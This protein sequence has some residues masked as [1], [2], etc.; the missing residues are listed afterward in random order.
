MISEVDDVN[1]VFDNG[2]INGRL[3]PSDLVH[4]DYV[5]GNINYLYTRYDYC[6][7]YIIL[8]DKKYSLCKNNNML[9]EY[10]KTV[11]KIDF[12]GKE[13]LLKSEDNIQ[14]IINELVEKYNMPQEL[15]ANVEEYLFNIKAYTR[16][17]FFEAIED[18]SDL[19]ERFKTFYKSYIK[20]LGLSNFEELM[21]SKDN[22]VAKMFKEDVIDSFFH[23]G[24]TIDLCNTYARVVYFFKEADLLDNKEKLKLQKEIRRCS[25]ESPIIYAN[26]LLSLV[27]YSCGFVKEINNHEGKNIQIFEYHNLEGVD[28]LDSLIKI[29]NSLLPSIKKNCSSSEKRTKIENKISEYQLRLNKKETRKVRLEEKMGK[30]DERNPQKD[31]L[32][33]KYTEELNKLNKEISEIES[34]ISRMQLRK[35]EYV[36]EYVDYNEFFRHLRNS[37]A[38]ANY[39]IDYIKALDKKQFNQIKYTF[40]DF[41]DDNPNI[42]EF[43]LEI[44]AR[45]LLKLVESLEKRVIKQTEIENT[46]EYYLGNNNTDEELKIKRPNNE[47]FENNVN[48]EILYEVLMGSKSNLINLLKDTEEKGID[49]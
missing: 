17:N 28:W 8:G 14:D 4:F 31:K 21:T 5:L 26:I 34:N 35:N 36:S 1:V 46:D 40:E 27:N 25:N 49:D 41:S 18:K 48:E 33:I 38:H 7:P 24:P 20:Y 11:K 42:P 23:N 47:D 13:D 16:F 32:E 45:H 29:D 19:F 15:K 39:S 44:D 9:Q 12:K 3:K 30:L 43:K 6:E 10:F 22:Y 2:K 37:I